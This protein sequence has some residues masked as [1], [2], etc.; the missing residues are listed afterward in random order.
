MSHPSNAP[1]LKL[2]IERKEHLGDGEP[3]NCS[4]L[5][6]PIPSPALAFG[7]GQD[8]NDD[9]SAFSTTMPFHYS[10]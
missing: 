3:R 7:I 4:S 5:R 2:E 8:G 6:P 10:K 9:D 1:A